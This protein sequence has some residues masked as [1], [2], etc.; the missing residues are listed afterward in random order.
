MN[1]SESEREGSENCCYLWFN[2]SSSDTKTGQIVDILDKGWWMWSCQALGTEEN[3]RRTTEE[4]QRRTTE[5]GHGCHE[6][7]C[8]K[9]WCSIRANPP[10]N[11]WVWMQHGSKGWGLRVFLQ[12]LTMKREKNAVMLHRAGKTT[13]RWWFS[14]V[15]TVWKLMIIAASKPAWL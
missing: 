10:A 1:S 15:P 4:P 9:G 13:V 2:D 6:R 7:R 5:E 14:V 11:Q 12:L 3:H 8:G